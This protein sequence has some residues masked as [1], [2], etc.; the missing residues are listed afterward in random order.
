[1][2][3]KREGPGYDIFD[4]R[5]ASNN[6]RIGAMI[7]FIGV[8]VTVASCAVASESGG[9]V[10]AYGAILVGAFQFL[11]GLFQAMRLR[12]EG[13]STDGPGQDS[14][15]SYNLGNGPEGRSGRR[16]GLWKFVVMA[17]LGLVVVAI[18]LQLNRK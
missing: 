16:S 3:E 5:N 1:M 11:G 15:I 18:L 17:W 13:K 14:R 2:P 4:P 8:V 9:F 7:C 10:L 6:M 12:G